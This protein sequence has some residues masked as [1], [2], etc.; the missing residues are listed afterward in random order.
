MMNRRT[1]LAGMAGAPLVQPV[2]FLGSGPKLPETLMIAGSSA[3]L[4][5]LRDLCDEFQAGRPGMRVILEGGGSTPGLAAARRGAIDLAAVSRHLTRTEDD[6]QIR[7]WLVAMDAIALVVHPSNPVH[8][9]SGDDVRAIFEGGIVNWSALG[10]ANRPIAVIHR[11]S[12]RSTTRR[13]LEEL[14]LQYADV[15]SNARMVESY[16]DMIAAVAG[17]P[18]AI[19]YVALRDIGPTLKALAVDGVP[20]TRPTILSG[21]YPYC[22]PFY[23]VGRPDAT[24]VTQAFLD[25][26]RGDVGQTMLAAKG[27]V[28]VG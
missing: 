3:M 22:R 28:R 21:R 15:S 12:P 1:F 20:V 26:V 19:G 10:G 17:A 4:L 7:S 8:N 5:Y 16:T 25:Y 2:S 27:L 6:D 11:L 23:L 14:V 18:D 9:L 24:P 13:S